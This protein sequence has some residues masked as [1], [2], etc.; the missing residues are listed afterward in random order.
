MSY[1]LTTNKLLIT[2]GLIVHDA[3]TVNFHDSD[4]QLEPCRQSL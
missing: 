2:T 1:L 3:K 4:D